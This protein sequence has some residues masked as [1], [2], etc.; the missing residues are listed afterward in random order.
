MNKIEIYVNSK[1][2][3][4]DQFNPNHLS[5]EIVSY[6]ENELRLI[7][8]KEMFEIEI[9]SKENLSTLEQEKV[10]ELIR[11]HYGLLV[12]KEMLLQNPRTMKKYLL[13][14]IGV[15]LITFSSYFLKDVLKELVLI[16]GWVAVWEVVYDVLFTDNINRLKINRNKKISSCKI[17]FFND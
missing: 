15:L 8:I 9:H 1:E 10:V 12:Q 3:F 16:A 6:L 7:Q 5:R 13:L 4:C 11:E 2:D 17:E 14:L